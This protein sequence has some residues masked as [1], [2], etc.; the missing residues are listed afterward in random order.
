MFNS[1]RNARVRRSLDRTAAAF[2]TLLREEPYIKITVSQLSELAGITRKTYY[3]NFL[4]ME[5][6]VDYV[7]F[8]AIHDGLRT[9]ACTSLNEY[10]NRFFSFC[11]ENREVFSLLNERGLFGNLSS[12]LQRYMSR[13]AFLDKA[14]NSAGLT[15]PEVD[16]FWNSLFGAEISLLRYWLDEDWRSSS[17]EM[18]AL[19]E[20]GFK[21]FLRAPI[22]G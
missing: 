12:G 5:D 16:V 10:L 19:V 15:Q 3:R 14:L 18:T 2:L 6:V 13:S 17:E 1:S 21:K 9:N 11:Y 8:K 7:V 20:R 22:W 4:S